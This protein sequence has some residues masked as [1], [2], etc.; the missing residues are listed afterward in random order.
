M[1]EILKVTRD[2]GNVPEEIKWPRAIRVWWVLMYMGMHPS[3][4]QREVMCV[5]QKERKREDG[6]RE[7][8]IFH[9]YCY[10][11]TKKFSHQKNIINWA[12]KK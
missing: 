6:E 8:I 5:G 1:S 10:D 4:K 3:M 9:K 11:I 7:R 2:R 12:N